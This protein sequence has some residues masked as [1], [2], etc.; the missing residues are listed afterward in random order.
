MRYYILDKHVSDLC[1]F[2][3]W[4]TVAAA[5]SSMTVTLLFTGR[6]I[7]LYLPIYRYRST[8]RFFG[9]SLAAA[10]AAAAACKTFVK[11]RTCPV[12]NV[13]L[14]ILFM[15]VIY[16]VNNII[17]ILYYFHGTRVWLLLLLLVL[18]VSPPPQPYVIHTLFAGY[19]RARDENG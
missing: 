18:V 14:S 19:R 8:A 5:A 16:V 7:N 9:V 15:P 11:Y 10:A 4:C 17:C 1:V 13:R 2:E 12:K 3:P 6:L